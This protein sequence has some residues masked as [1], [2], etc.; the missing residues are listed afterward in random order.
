MYKYS[1]NLLWSY[2]IIIYPYWFEPFL[3]RKLKLVTQQYLACQTIY[4]SFLILNS[5]QGLN[6]LNLKIVT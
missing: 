4:P 2:Y 1:S 5:C 3:L 6:I